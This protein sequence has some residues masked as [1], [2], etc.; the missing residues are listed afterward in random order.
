MTV[1]NAGLNAVEWIFFAGQILHVGS[2][3]QTPVQSVA[4]AMV[5]TLDTARETSRRLGAHT[6][7]A[8]S[9]DIIESPHRTGL[10]TGDDN[11]FSRK[12]SQ[13]VV[14]GIR[15]MIGAANADPVAKIEKFEL[16]GEQLGIGVVAS[17]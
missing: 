5:R 3:H 4:P 7:A 12:L 13:K 2:A 1:P 17:G 11:A 15:N 8:V 6:S 14:A 9:T 16:L 10:V